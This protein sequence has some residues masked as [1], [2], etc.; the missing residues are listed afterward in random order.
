MQST[1]PVDLINI[2]NVA[3]GVGSARERGKSEGSEP[4]S[5]STPTERPIAHLVSVQEVYEGV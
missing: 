1:D 3:Q 5:S 2:K 4:R